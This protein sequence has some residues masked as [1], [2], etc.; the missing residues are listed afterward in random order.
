MYSDEIIE[1]YR[2]DAQGL[3]SYLG[4]DYFS[5]HEK[6]F[7]INPFQIMTDLGIHFVF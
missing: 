2:N 7:P 5:R 1:Q 4:D 3:A 6:K